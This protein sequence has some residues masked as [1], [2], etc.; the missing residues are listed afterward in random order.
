M[1]ADEAAKQR[2]RNTGLAVMHGDPATGW[3]LLQWHE[4]PLGGAGLEDPAAHD[5]TGE[6]PEEAVGES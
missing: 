6:S 3:E 4:E 5:V 2:I 1:D